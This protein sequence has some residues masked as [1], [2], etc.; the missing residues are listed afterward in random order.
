MPYSDIAR[1][2]CAPRDKQ[3]KGA[4][5]RTGRAD[6]VRVGR[7]DSPARQRD[8]LMRLADRVNAADGVLTVAS[9]L[10]ERGASADIVRRYASPVGRKMAAAYRLQ[11]EQTT[12][13][14]TGVADRRLVRVLGYKLSDAPLLDAVIDGYELADP[15]S[16][17]KGR[18]APRIRLTDL[19]GGG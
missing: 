19:I 14:A 10:R 12:L 3:R 1:S 11:D 13:N 2:I 18:K 5:V 4:P 6:R 9:H 8:I 17:V 7:Y 16:P 15:N